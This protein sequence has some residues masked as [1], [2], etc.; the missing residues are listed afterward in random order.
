[1]LYEVIT[2]WVMVVFLMA[3]AGCGGDSTSQVSIV[4]PEWNQGDWWSVNHVKTVSGV[5][6][7]ST[8]TYVV[9]QRTATSVTVGDGTTV[10]TYDIADGKF[11]PTYEE[12]APEPA[13]SFYGSETTYSSATAFCP[14][15]AA[16]QSYEALTWIMA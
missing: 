15:P 1:M 8:S 12:K 6:T 10:K 4:C 13:A 11:V 7:E 16:G 5:A 14:P 9:T 3:L 2:S